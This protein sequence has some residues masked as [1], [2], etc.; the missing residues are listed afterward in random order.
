MYLN[1]KFKVT[2]SSNSNLAVKNIILRVLVSKG[3][4]DDV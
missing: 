4:V 3:D 2:H 1:F